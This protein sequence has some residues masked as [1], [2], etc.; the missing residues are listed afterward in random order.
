MTRIR[1][2]LRLA[3]FVG[4]FALDSRFDFNQGFDTYDEDFD[5]LVGEGGADQIQRSGADVTDAVI[6]YLSGI[7]MPKHL[8][9]FVH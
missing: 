9:L 8:F 6:H 3:G 4:S 1:L 5:V 2:L 7:A